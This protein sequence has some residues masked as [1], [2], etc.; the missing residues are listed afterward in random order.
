MDAR[1]WDR[2]W[3]DKLLHAHGEPSSVVLDAL[4]HLAPGRALDLGCGNGRP[5][6]GWPSEDGA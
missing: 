1:D 6:C 3:K 2:R 4:D 5:R